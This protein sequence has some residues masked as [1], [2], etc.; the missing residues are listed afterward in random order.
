MK[1]SVLPVKSSMKFNIYDSAKNHRVSMYT[2]ENGFA[3]ND[4]LAHYL[5]DN[6]YFE[7]NVLTA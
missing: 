7:V 6:Q 4:E 3:M 5:N 2:I 1:K